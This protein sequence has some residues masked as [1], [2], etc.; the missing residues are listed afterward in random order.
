MSM[1]AGID[2]DINPPDSVPCPHSRTPVRGPPPT[3]PGG[4][5]VHDGG[6]TPS[7]LGQGG[8]PGAGH[9]GAVT[10]DRARGT[11]HVVQTLT[12]DEVRGAEAT[13]VTVDIGAETHILA[14]VLVAPWTRPI[15]EVGR[16][17]VKVAVEL[18][19]VPIHQKFEGEMSTLPFHLPLLSLCFGVVLNTHE[20]QA[21]SSWH[22]SCSFLIASILSPTFPINTCI[23]APIHNARINP[24]L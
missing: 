22:K 18:L 12:R 19:L 8:V 23:S 3:V 4:E 6:L 13:P 20:H 15:V 9:L 17:L 5:G 11:R 21:P 14:R 1:T 16:Q 7:V 24:N 2:S 10:H